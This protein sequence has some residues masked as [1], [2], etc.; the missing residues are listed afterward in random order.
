MWK[1]KFPSE[2]VCDTVSEALAISIWEVN[3]NET[4]KGK[5]EEKE[6][7]VNAMREDAVD[8]N[9]TSIEK[10]DGVGMFSRCLFYINRL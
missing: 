7:L 1:L 8:A 3:Y 10:N 6:Y 9:D 2:E 5:A 4:Y